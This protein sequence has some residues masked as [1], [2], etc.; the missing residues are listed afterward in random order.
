MPIFS[1]DANSDAIAKI[2][3]GDIFGTVDQSITGQ[4]GG[5]YM[6]ARNLI[7]HPEYS[8]LEAV[9]YGF[10]EK[11]ATSYGYIKSGFQTFDQ[12]TNAMLCK[13]ISV[14]KDNVDKFYNKSVVTRLEENE[15]IVRD[16]NQKT[17]AKVYHSYY[18]ATDNFLNSSMRPLF[19]NLSTKFN[20]DVTSTFGNG[21]D[22]AL[23]LDNLNTN[24]TKGKYYQA[25]VLNMVKT[26]SAKSYLDAIYNVYQENGVVNVPI[27]FWNRQPTNEFSQVDKESMHDKRFKHI[28]YVGFDAI[29]GGF[30]QGQ[31]IKDYLINTIEA[32]YN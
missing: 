6:V 13:N 10:S 23:S 16:E 28:L 21:N 7:D 15:K 11:F 18:S 26:T 4:A 25:F 14:T 29:Q 8:D 31:M 12:V 9:K 1:Y 19:E 20:F 17:N 2:K 32:K 27:I 22:E 30:I 24:L 5:I 3:S